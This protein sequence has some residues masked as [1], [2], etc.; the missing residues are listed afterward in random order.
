MCWK[1]LVGTQV[2]R[3]IDA[4]VY[5]VKCQHLANELSAILHCSTH[6]VVDLSPL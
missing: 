1:L 4:D 6:L 3:M 5:L 2:G